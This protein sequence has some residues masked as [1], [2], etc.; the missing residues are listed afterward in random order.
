MEILVDYDIVV[1][2]SDNFATRYLVNDACVLSGK[3]L[4]TGAVIGFEAQ[5]TTVIPKETACYRYIFPA[6][7][8][9]GFAPSCREAGVIG[10][11]C[12][13]I[14][15]VLATE[16]IELILGG[17]NLLT[18]QLFLCNLKYKYSGTEAVPL[19]LV[20]GRQVVWLLFV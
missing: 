3:P 12:G 5:G 1:D 13:V 6:P 18:N 10:T 17:G 9:L 8:P 11:I 20:V 14:G 7:S 19:S 2:G 15:C 4:V 16:V